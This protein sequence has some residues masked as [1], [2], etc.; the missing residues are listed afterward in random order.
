LTR[1]SARDFARDPEQGEPAAQVSR[2]Y[3]DEAQVAALRAYG[4][5]EARCRRADQA[6]DLRVMLAGAVIGAA[7]MAA[8]IVGFLR[9]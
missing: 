2:R 7:A 5:P 8:F 3:D 9:P 4:S 1:I 6:R